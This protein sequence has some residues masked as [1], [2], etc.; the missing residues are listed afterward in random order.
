MGLVTRY[1]SAFF[2]VLSMVSGPVYASCGE[3]ADE[4]EF[5]VPDIPTAA[6][7]NKQILVFD[8]ALKT[9]IDEKIPKQLMQKAQAIVVANTKKG[10]FIIAIEA[11]TG[12]ISVYNGQNWSN[13]AFITLSAASVGFQAGVDFKTIVLVF[14]NR[15]A[16]EKVVAGNLKLG[17]GLDIV[18]GPLKAD[19]GT[20]TV[21]DKEVYSYSD[22]MG[23]FAGVSLKGSS[24]SVDPLPNQ[25]LYGKECLTASQIFYGNL[26]PSANEANKFKATLEAASK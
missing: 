18:A 13:P 15:E 22:G 24:I 6:T 3:D 8:T 9:V 19:V 5:F 12:L 16:A 25:G 23:L 14:T 10:G 20:N 1:I 4:D 11:G 7:L 26:V 2:I 21:F 17:V